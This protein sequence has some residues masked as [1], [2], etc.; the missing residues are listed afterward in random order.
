MTIGS[1]TN[2]ALAIKVDPEF[3]G[4][5][6]HLYVGAGHIEGKLTVRSYHT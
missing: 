4:R 3:L 6:T 5:L 1:L 2:V